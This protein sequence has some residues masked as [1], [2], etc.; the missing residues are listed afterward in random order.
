MFCSRILDN[1]RSLSRSF[2]DIWCNSSFFFEKSAFSHQEMIFCRGFLHHQGLLDTG[3]IHP[4]LRF[5]VVVAMRPCDVRL[6]N[7]C[8]MLQ[9]F[10]SFLNLRLYIEFFRVGKPCWC[11][12]ERITFESFLPFCLQAFLRSSVIAS[13]LL[14]FLPGPSK[15]PFLLLK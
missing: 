3:W 13:D 2:F 5:T 7:A 11:G 12:F 4:V 9:F 6:G 10:S 14:I 15:P 1:F 8:L